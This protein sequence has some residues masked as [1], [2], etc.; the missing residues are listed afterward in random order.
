M[1]KYCILILLFLCILQSKAIES[2]SQTTKLSLKVE[3][4]AL[5]EIFKIVEKNSE[6]LFNYIDNDVNGIKANVHVQDGNIE[7]ILSQSLK[8]TGL[9]YSINNRH[10]TIFKAGKQ[11]PQAPVQEK[12]ITVTGTV[13]DENNLPLIGCSVYLK[14]NPQK[15]VTTNEEGQF[16][17]S[18]P[19]NA[20]LVFTYI[21]YTDNE[22]KINN[23]TV[24][25]VKMIPD[26]KLL[27]EVVVVG[28][29]VQKK[30]N[31]TGAVATV[32][33]SK[34]ESRATTN[35][36]SALSGLAAGVTVR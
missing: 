21:G 23:R 31:L 14:S 1:K 11:I 30:V 36:S 13:L 10:I 12:E 20:I 5:T 3:K 15:G 28:Y 9:S 33:N 17:I 6:Y 32:S 18:V 2:Y 16:T 35:L 4:T 22:V 8:N 19:G 27:E 34:L 29:G 7:E 25:E 26:T 24:L